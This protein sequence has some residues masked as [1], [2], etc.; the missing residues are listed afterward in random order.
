[1]IRSLVEL[2]LSY[3]HSREA[4]N[5][6]DALLGKDR[7]VFQRVS[8]QM[9]CRLD[10]RLFGLESDGATLNL[11]LGGVGLVAPVAWPEGSQVKVHLSDMDLNGIIVYRK[12]PVLSSKDC[13]YGVKFQRLKMR[14]L[15]K[16]RKVLQK[17]YQGPLAV[18]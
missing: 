13:R 12:D 17:N 1:M 7:R 6:R 5:P 14:D 10:N 3:R 18:L 4:W 11:S 15:L 9:P 2:F 8:V 16:L